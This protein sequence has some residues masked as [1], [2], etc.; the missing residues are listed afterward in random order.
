V[1]LVRSKEALAE[2]EAGSACSSEKLNRDRGMLSA[3]T[4]RMN[5]GPINQEPEVDKNLPSS[6]LKIGTQR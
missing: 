3:W 4:E 6:E 5:T 1:L 2:I